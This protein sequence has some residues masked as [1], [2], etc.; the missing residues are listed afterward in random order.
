M[1]SI[2]G[3]LAA[4]AFCLGLG[5][6]A[7]SA[8]TIIDFEDV[9]GG[10]GIANATDVSTHYLPQGVTFTDPFTPS[11]VVAGA[12]S[13]TSNTFFA[14]QGGNSQPNG[15]ADDL[16]ISFSVPVTSFSMNI[17]RNQGF[18]F[19]YQIFGNSG[20]LASG[21]SGVNSLP[22]GQNPYDFNYSNATEITFLLLTTH[23]GVNPGFFGG[24]R[25]DDLTFAGPPVVGG[26]PEPSTWAMLL[27]GFAGM[28]YVARWRGPRTWSSFRR[29]AA[30]A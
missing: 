2:S 23:S 30:A 15:D 20:L 4:S 26:V 16:K 19:S 29:A 13:F 17:F 21:A 5:V 28:A 25:L 8:T 1:K 14:R 24:F 11:G 27:I 9:S 7:A 18:F 3:I 6:A 10:V 12:G 22:T